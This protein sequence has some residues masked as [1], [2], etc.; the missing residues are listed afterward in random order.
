M[1]L[2]ADDKVYCQNNG[3]TRRNIPSKNNVITCRVR[4]SESNPPTMTV[5]VNDEILSSGPPDVTTNFDRYYDGVI[6][7]SYN[8]PENANSSCIVTDTRGTYRLICQPGK[9]GFRH[10]MYEKWQRTSQIFFLKQYTEY[11]HIS[12]HKR[13]R[14]FKTLLK[15]W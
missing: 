13:L 14:W 1:S 9:C 12:I 15:F 5:K 11:V 7:A 10:C 8:V 4:N 6:T 2:A 3:G